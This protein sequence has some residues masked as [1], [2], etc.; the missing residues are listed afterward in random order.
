MVWSSLPKISIIRSGK[1]SDSGAATTAHARQYAEQGSSWHGQQQN[2]QGTVD[3]QR[4]EDMASQLLFT[5]TTTHNKARWGTIVAATPDMSTPIMCDR[6]G[7][8]AVELKVQGDNPE[9]TKM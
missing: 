2:Q 6:Q 1:R 7:L 5:K 8:V 4:S 9:T 3:H